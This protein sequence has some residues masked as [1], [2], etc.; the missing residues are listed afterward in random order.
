MSKSVAALAVGVI[1]AAILF[2]SC[3]GQ[4]AYQSPNE[5]QYSSNRTT[6]AQTEDEYAITY[7]LTQYLLF[8]GLSGGMPIDA[9]E[10]PKEEPENFIEEFFS[11]FG[12]LLMEEFQKAMDDEVM[13]QQSRILEHLPALFGTNPEAELEVSIT[14]K[15]LRV[16][17]PPAHTGVVAKGGRIDCFPVEPSDSRDDL[18]EYRKQCGTFAVYTYVDGTLSQPQATLSFDLVLFPRDE[19]NDDSPPPDAPRY[20]Q[21]T[22]LHLVKDPDWKIVA[23]QTRAGETPAPQS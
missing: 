7:A 18:R 19:I 21:P 23:I 20:I 8:C 11:G 14:A 6:R 5:G 17:Y 10:A 4:S 13:A 2:P 9:P 22:V 12:D 16:A 1:L 15:T 3:A